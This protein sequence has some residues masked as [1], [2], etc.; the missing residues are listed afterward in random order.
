MVSSYRNISPLCDDI[1]EMV[2]EETHKKRLEIW[3]REHTQEMRKCFQEISDKFSENIEEDWDD[4]N[5][6][7]LE[8]P[9]NFLNRLDEEFWDQEFTKQLCVS[10]EGLWD[11]IRDGFCAK[12]G[13]W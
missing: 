2:G 10:E 12:F 1:L 6:Y 9:F 5:Y 11:N 13:V 4:R 3:R 7:N 8:E